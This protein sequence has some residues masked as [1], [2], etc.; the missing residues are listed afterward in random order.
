M[1]GLNG[2]RRMASPVRLALARHLGSDIDGAWWPHTGSVANEL[3]DLVGVLHRSLGEVVDIRVNW[4]AAEG[5]L[6]LDSIV[7]GTRG[8]TGMKLSRP[9]LMM[10]AGRDVCVKLLVVPSKTSVGL[11]ALVMRCAA[12]MPVGEAERRTPAYDTA[13]RVLRVAQLESARWLGHL[14]DPTEAPV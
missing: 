14:K 13:D 7:P 5:Q 10:V 4:S 11:G 3:P 2:T 1:N 8:P 9:R 12:A 6:D